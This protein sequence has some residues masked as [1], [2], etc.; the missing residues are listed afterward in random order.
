MR[1]AIL[2]L[3]GSR[4]SGKKDFFAILFFSTL[5][6]QMHVLIHCFF[7]CLLLRNNVYI[8][9][10]RPYISDVTYIHTH[11]NQDTNECG[12]LLERPRAEYVP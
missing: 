2:E 4:E 5:I 11:N 9:E 10:I 8:H 1:R 6:G 12:P 7:C 3:F